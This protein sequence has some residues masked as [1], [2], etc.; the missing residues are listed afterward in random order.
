MVVQIL[1][2]LLGNFGIHLVQLVFHALT[3]DDAVGGLVHLAFQVGHIL[4]CNVGVGVCLTGCGSVVGRL[5]ILVH[6]VYAFLDE[7]GL[8]MLLT[9]KYI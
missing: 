5:T 1:L 9:I 7:A 2:M 3:L 6:I 4:H 8:S